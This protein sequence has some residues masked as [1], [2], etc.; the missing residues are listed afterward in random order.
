MPSLACPE[1]KK[2][3]LPQNLVP[4]G[5]H[6]LCPKCGREIYEQK[7]EVTKFLC[8]KCGEEATSDNFLIVEA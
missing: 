6:L 4:K 3:L 2:E 8:P 7:K 1:C 5:E